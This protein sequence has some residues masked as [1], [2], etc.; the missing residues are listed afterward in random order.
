MEVDETKPGK[1]R[2]MVAF[3]HLPMRKATCALAAV[4][5]FSAFA[6]GSASAAEPQRI[7]DESLLTIRSFLGDGEAKAMRPLLKAGAG[8]V[9]LP[10]LVH[11]AI[12]L[13]GSGGS[14]VIVARDP[15]TG[16]WSYPVFVDMGSVSLG[17][18]F[19]VSSTEVVLVVMNRNALDSLLEG[20]IAV[21]GSAG[22]VAGYHD[23][24][25]KAVATTSG[26]SDIYVFARSKGAYAG[27]ALEG[28]AL[29]V[30]PERNA[31]YYGA[32]F[33]AADALAG[34][35]TGNPGAENLRMALPR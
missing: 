6:A 14:G 12:G 29:R 8:V 21:G 24:G 26:R 18:Q 10:G 16:Q 23:A 33:S 4:G 13:G 11:A 28:A 15:I 5:L 2:A 31:R 19:G 9:I 30:D 17:P 25:T 32:A 22:A 34:T 3:R 20:G 1:E 35:R 27:A 7:V